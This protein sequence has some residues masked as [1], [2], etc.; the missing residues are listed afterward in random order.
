[1]DGDT[2]LSRR[3]YLFGLALT[4]LLVSG[5]SY[6]DST[7]PETTAIAPLLADAD[8]DRIPDAVGTVVT[9][10]GVAVSSAFNV[11]VDDRRLTRVFIDDGTAGILLQVV[12]SDLLSNVTA[13]DELQVAGSLGFYYGSPVL[14]PISAATL[15]KQPVPEPLPVSIADLNTDKHEG[16]LIVATGRLVNAQNVELVDGQHAVRVRARNALLEDSGFAARFRSGGPARVVGIATQYDPSAPHTGGYRIELLDTDKGIVL[17]TDYGWLYPTLLVAAVIAFLGWLTLAARRQAERDRRLLQEVEASQSALTLSEQKLQL[18]ARATSD[19]VWELFIDDDRLVRESGSNA[20]FLESVEQ[21]ELIQADLFSRVHLDDRERVVTSFDEAINGDANLWKEEYRIVRADGRTLYLR[22]QALIQRDEAGKANN[23]VGAVQDITAIS[24]EQAR[25]AILDAKLQHSQKT[26][27]L[28]VLAGGIAHDFNNILAVIIG[29]AEMLRQKDVSDDKRKARAEEIVKAAVRGSNLSRRM[30]AYAGKAPVA[31][32]RL[33]I[34]TIVRDTQSMLSEVLSKKV[35]LV[36]ELASELPDVMGDDGQLQQVIMNLVINGA[37]SCGDTSGEVRVSTELR[38]LTPEEVLQTVSGRFPVEKPYVVLSVSDT[39]CGMSADMQAR[40]FEPFYSSKGSSRGMGLS[41]VIGIINTHGGHLLLQSAENR[42]SEF[43]VLFEP[44]GADEDSAS[45][46]MLRTS[47]ADDTPLD[48][49]V[50]VADDEDGIREFEA[51][52]LKMLGADVIE[53][54]NGV[55][56]LELYQSHRDSLSLII[57]DVSMPEMSGVEVYEEI[58]K[59]NSKLPIIIISGLGAYEVESQVR[60]VQNVR[61]L[62][63][64]I[65]Q[66]DLRNA[67]IRLYTDSH[68]GTTE[69]D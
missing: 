15:G 45:P 52:T 40:I 46:A 37:E 3:G 54:R 27:S 13:G 68:E 51:A 41:A 1:M 62:S 6:P 43:K 57:L 36:E 10:Q 39:G 7:V 65:S 59:T 24:E 38:Q 23:V 21:R 18:V 11:F 33:S 28:G 16:R 31:K 14:A 30:L 9:L 26:E 44:L 48:G 4:T 61:F 29:Q 22:D 2:G 5:P 47:E 19:A 12:D 63:K 49:V 60:T 53:A 55:E 67:V 69:E 20:L 17:L 8:G 66:K 50:L 64:P 35:S 25:Q 34:N 42:G 58:R 32:Q 56:A